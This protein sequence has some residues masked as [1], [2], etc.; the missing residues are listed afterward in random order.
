LAESF[1]SSQQAKAY[2]RDSDRKR[3]ES[4][5]LDSAQCGFL[6]WRRLDQRRDEKQAKSNLAKI[7]QID[8]Q[9]PARRA[10]KRNRWL[11]PQIRQTAYNK[12]GIWAHEAH[13][14]PAFAWPRRGRHEM[15]RDIFS[16]GAFIS[17]ASFRVFSGQFNPSSLSP[18]HKSSKNPLMTAD[19]RASSPIYSACGTGL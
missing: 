8:R 17:F 7:V 2:T 15:G 16:S 3:P 13:R 18:A 4:L 5:I 12:D 1:W 11:Y 19:T 10:S 6:P 9:C 14:L